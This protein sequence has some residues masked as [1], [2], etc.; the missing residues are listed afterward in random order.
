MN[1]YLIAA[2]LFSIC[3]PVVFGADDLCSRIPW[4]PVQ[5][6]KTTR[7]GVLL[8]SRTYPGEVGGISEPVSVDG[9]AWCR[10]SAQVKRLAGD[11]RYKL[12]VEWLDANRK[13]IGYDNSW[14]GQLVGNAPESYYADVLAPENARFVA[15]HAGIEPGNACVMSQITLGKSPQSAVIAPVVGSESSRVDAH[16]SYSRGTIT[17]SPLPAPQPLKTPFMLGCYYFPVMIDWDRASWGVRRVDYL[18]P[19]LGYYDEA[20]PEVADWH[21]RWAVEHGISLFVFDW[22]Y[23]QD[24]FYLNDALEKGFMKSRHVGLMKFCLDWCNE[25]QCTE[26][27]PL[28]FSHDSL[29]SFIRTLCDRYFAHASYLKIEGKPVVLIHQ[30]WRIVNTHEDWSGC[31]RALDRMR[32]VARSNGHAGVYF[33]AVHNNACVPRYVDGGFDAITSYAYGFCDVPFGPDRANSYEAIIPR[34]ER[35][36]S[37]ARQRTREQQIGFI[38]TGWLGWDDAARSNKH[39]VRTVGNTPEAARP[40]IEMLPRHIDPKLNIALFEAWNEWGEGGAAEPGKQYGFGY[41]DVIRSV[42]AP[43]AGPHEDWLPSTSELEQFQTSLDYDHINDD[44]YRRYLRTLDLARGFDMQFESRRELWL[45]PVSQLMHVQF[46]AG[47]LHAQAIGSD[48]ILVSPPILDLRADAVRAIQVTMSVTA[49]SRAELY[50]SSDQAR[51][52]DG[53]RSAAIDL[54][55]D[56]KMRT[57]EIP[58]A[59]NPTWTGIIRQLRFDPTDAPG[60][61][62]LDRFATISPSSSVHVRGNSP[63]ISPVKKC[64]SDKVSK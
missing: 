25:G 58:V 56:G 63:S 57:Y 10:V 37:Q 55:A 38:P 31:R 9:N 15:I 4:A 36:M 47:T 12:A 61:I 23:N 53:S 34:Y 21:I 41:L 16:G 44:Y 45:R 42:L 62:A 43:D 50:W 19:L 52:F 60:P 26:Y 49:G 33:V 46:E 32:E 1:R 27:K 51:S 20:R 64:E 40:M 13:H 29:E 14:T 6:V 39:A 48:P 30:P 22:Y 28:D 3:P 54:I 17:P 35:A 11:G 24:M 8:D 18:T 59:N 5:H 2:C 7:E